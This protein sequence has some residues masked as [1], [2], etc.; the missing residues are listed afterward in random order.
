[1]YSLVVGLPFLICVFKLIT[2]FDSI[3]YV[4]DMKAN[5][6]D[7]YD[8]LS[9]HHWEAPGSSH[10]IRLISLIVSVALMPRT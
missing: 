4:F 5:T 6:K 1:M 7:A 3:S 9:K 8:K 10:P 2:Q